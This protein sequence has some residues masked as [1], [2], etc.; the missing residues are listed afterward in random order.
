LGL[1]AGILKKIV[2]R[3]KYEPKSKDVTVTN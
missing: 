2:S 3:P 1:I